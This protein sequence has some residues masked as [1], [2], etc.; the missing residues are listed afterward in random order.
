MKTTHVSTIILMATWLCGCA[1]PVKPINLIVNGDFEAG[2]TG[3]ASEYQL[4]TST[5]IFAN[6]RH[7]IF[8]VMPV[9]D[10]AQSAGY[11]DW[12]N[13]R[14]DARGSNSLV[15]V[16]DGSTKNP[17]AIVWSQTVSVRPNTRYIFSFNAVEVSNPC[18]SNAVIVPSINGTSGTPLN[19]NS[20]WQVGGM[21]WNSGSANSATVALRDTNI[22]GPYNDFA[23]DDLS[24]IQDSGSK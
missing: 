4:S 9:S 21:I 24:L 16:A 13:L 8:A 23:L 22:A 20:K 12:K 1:A 14:L 6:N 5:P 11:G 17:P 7:G 2:N 10:I 15:L 18:C 19:L 3:F